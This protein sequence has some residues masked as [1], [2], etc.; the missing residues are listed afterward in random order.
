[1]NIKRWLLISLVVTLIQTLANPAVVLAKPTA[2]FTWSLSPRYEAN[3]D[4]WTGTTYDPN[5]VNPKT[6]RVNFDA[7]SSQGGGSQVA[8]YSWRIEGKSLFWFPITFTTTE[9]KKGF[10]VPGQGAYQATLSIRT[11][12]NQTSSSTKTVIVKDWL[13]VSI[14]DSMSSGEGNPDQP[15]DYDVTFNSNLKTGHVVINRAAVWKDRRCHRSAWSGP[16]QTAKTL[17]DGDPYTSVTFLS[18]ACSGAEITHVYS[19]T[20]NGEEPQ[21]E[22][23][24]LPPQIQAVRELVG[25]RQIDALLMTA[26]INDLLFSDIVTACA[27]NGN[28]DWRKPFS[29]PLDDPN[30]VDSY[31]I[32]NRLAGLPDKYDALASAISDNLNVAE[33][34]VIDYPENVLDGGGCGVLSGITSNEADSIELAARQL[35]IRIRDAADKHHW[36]MVHGDKG[37]TLTEA[38]QRDGGHSYCA[39]STWFVGVQESFQKQGPKL[40][41]LHPNFKGHQAIKDLFL[42]SIRLGQRYDTFTR[43]TLTIEAV[44][45]GKST[46][47]GNGANV[48]VAVS[49]TPYS[50]PYPIECN[51]HISESDMG[52]YVNPPSNKCTFTLDVYHP[53]RS[54]RH[55]VFVDL[56]VLSSGFGQVNGDHLNDYRN[57]YGVGSYE[58]VNPN[59][60]L[61]VKYTITARYFGP[62]EQH[63]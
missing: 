44:K 18:F 45:T 34:Y 12:D 29:N 25:D 53:P 58:V 63:R 21:G 6:W 37:R 51:F 27:T 54:P 15:G 47:T 36:N 60:L 40:G 41:A 46:Q 61:A 43:V 38:F 30:C 57:N 35:T 31:D 14:G 50:P 17:E 9:C 52:K 48:R 13:I 42:K 2:Y 3:W 33:V 59:G 20:Y 24:K 62:L 49:G 10:N 26:G 22:T 55:A 23:S 56:V 1:M 32:D 19:D 28:F 5:Y 4:A 11:K 39:N 16:A 8:E 7:C